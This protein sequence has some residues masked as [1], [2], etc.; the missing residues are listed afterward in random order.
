MV[1]NGN[2]L[3]KKLFTPTAAYVAGAQSARVNPRSHDSSL[4]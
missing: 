3:L 4:A 2:F 1:K